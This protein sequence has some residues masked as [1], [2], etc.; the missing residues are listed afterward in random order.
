MREEK[1]ISF[2]E[3][4]ALVQ[5]AT[6]GRAVARR[7]ASIR[8]FRLTAVNVQ[9]LNE[10]SSLDDYSAVQSLSDRGAM[11]VPPSPHEESAVVR[12]SRKCEQTNH[13][14]VEAEEY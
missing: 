1:P 8:A 13:R 3:N 5:D 4:E 2:V 9:Y 10:L 11:A 12:C 7:I 14:D 6:S